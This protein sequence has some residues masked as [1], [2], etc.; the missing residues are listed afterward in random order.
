MSDERQ[1]RV[2]SRLSPTLRND[3]SI[4]TR[5]GGFRLRAYSLRHWR[6]IQIIN[7]ARGIDFPEADPICAF[8]RLSG[9][10]CRDYTTK[11]AIKVA[12]RANNAILQIVDIHYLS[13]VR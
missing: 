5:A 11:R 6:N 7:V 3:N 10:N 2:M 1:S 9:G 12:A 4:K 13:V 8:L